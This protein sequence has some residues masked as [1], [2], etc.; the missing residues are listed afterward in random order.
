MPVIMTPV[1]GSSSVF[2]DISAALDN[3]LN[4]MI[5]LPPVAWENK[6]YEPIKDTLF[7]KPV[8]LQGDTVAITASQDETI[9]VY[10]IDIS[11]PA[12]EG[13]GEIVLMTDMLANHFKQ[14]TEMAYLTQ[15]VRVRNVSRT[16]TSND[17]NGWLH[18]TV[19]VVY[20]AFSERR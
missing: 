9:G 16:P 19:D 2:L 7:L 13:K 18:A 5:G 4:N 3:R 14:D 6:D 10:Q 20:Y 15:T 1:A 12:G 17:E 11:A 8:N